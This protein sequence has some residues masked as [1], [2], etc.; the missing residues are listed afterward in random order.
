MYDR[1]VSEVL[2]YALVFSIVIVAV[3]IVSLSGVGAIE[4]A[5]TAEQSNNAQLA[6]DVFA[7]NVEDVYA[8]GAP[9]SATEINLEKATLR[10]GDPIAVDVELNDTDGQNVDP[11]P[12]E[13]D[14]V[15]HESESG[16][17]ISYE[18]GTVIRTGDRGGSIR[19][20]DPPFVF[21]GEGDDE[22]VVLPIVN[23]TAPTRTSVSGSTILIRTGTGSNDMTEREELDNSGR[24][25][26]I[27]IT[28]ESPRYEEWRAYFEAADFESCSTAPA[29]NEVSCTYEGEGASDPIEQVYLVEHEIPVELER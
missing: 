2:S 20:R 1:G 18:A 7:D 5:T 9:R 17:T 29:S 16:D 12:W 26:R 6:F 3:T 19:N 8:R 15:L 10:I 21:A 13:I 28:V 11:D 4:S 14:P 25:E 23:L 22:R 24:F 27:E